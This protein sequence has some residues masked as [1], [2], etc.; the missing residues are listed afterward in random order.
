MLMNDKHFL[1]LFQYQICEHEENEVDENHWV[2]KNKIAKKRNSFVD[3]VLFLYVFLQPIYAVVQDCFLQMDLID[4]Y[5]DV[6]THHQ[7][8]LQLKER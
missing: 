7:Y 8:S 1:W 4:R 3:V 5:N 2:T 6:Y